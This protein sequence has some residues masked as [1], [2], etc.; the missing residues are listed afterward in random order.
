MVLFVMFD[1]PTETK[2]DLKVYRRFRSKLLS[3]GFIMLQYSI[4]IRFCRSLAVAQKYEHY[5][6][7]VS[8]P[9]GSIRVLKITEAQFQNMVVVENY[10]KKP[11]EEITK[12][13]QT[14][15]VF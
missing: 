6:E 1:M 3:Y 8:P 2:K 14:T 7:E 12:Q 15:M 4:Y 11:E 9:N 5:I 13:G 10:R